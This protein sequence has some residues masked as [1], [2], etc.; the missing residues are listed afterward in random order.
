[1][2]RACDT[3]MP[4][5]EDIW[6]YKLREFIKDFI[7]NIGIFKSFGFIASILISL[8]LLNIIYILENTFAQKTISVGEFE[9]SMISTCLFLMIICYYELYYMDNILKWMWKE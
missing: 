4:K 8:Q 6:I 2:R 9:A 7:I 5:F 1:M 3:L